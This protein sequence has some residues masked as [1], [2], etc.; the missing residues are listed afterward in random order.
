MPSV[1]VKNNE[2]ESFCLAMILLY[3]AIKTAT[4]YGSPE[5]TLWMPCVTSLLGAATLFFTKPHNTT[6]TVSLTGA[7]HQKNMEE[8]LWGW[9]TTLATLVVAYLASCWRYQTISL[10]AVIGAFGGCAFMS[11]LALCDAIGTIVE[12]KEEIRRYWGKFSSNGK[13]L[14]VNSHFARRIVAQVGFIR[15][16]AH[17]RAYRRSSHRSSSTKQSSSD[18]GGP[19]DQ[20]DPPRHPTPFLIFLIFCKNSNNSS[21]PALL[22]RQL[23]Y[24][25]R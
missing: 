12:N 25:S 9:A 11:Y 18:D 16:S 17:A 13:Q 2:C 7:K 5:E 19:S 3:M 10:I 21:F 24:G 23:A 8:I 22:P 14:L 1:E 6:M 4:S 20:G 15:R